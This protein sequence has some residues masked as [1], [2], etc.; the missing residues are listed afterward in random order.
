MRV[1]PAAR[2]ARTMGCG[3]PP[4]VGTRKMA[5][6][7]T[8]A[9]RIC[10]SRPQVAK[11]PMPPG[12]SQ[13]VTGAPPASSIRFILPDTSTN[14]IDCPSGD[15]N[16]EVASSVPG[17]ASNSRASSRRS[18]MLTPVEPTRTWARREPSGDNAICEVS[19]LVKKRWSAGGGT[20]KRRR[21]TAAGATVA[22]VRNC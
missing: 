18:Q 1:S 9:N 15:Q 21:L 22:G 5:S 17:T 10:P 12:T 4:L 20:G 16:T 13:I 19:A 3:T 7:S 2:S 14:P 6:P 8:V 11:T